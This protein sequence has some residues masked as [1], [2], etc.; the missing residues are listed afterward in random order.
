MFF[1][2]YTT[3]QTF[4]WAKQRSMKLTFSIQYGDYLPPSL[5][6]SRTCYFTHSLGTWWQQQYTCTLVCLTR[7]RASSTWNLLRIHSIMGVCALSNTAHIK[8]CNAEHNWKHQTFFLKT[9]AIWF[10][11]YTMQ[12]TSHFKFRIPHS[13]EA[14]TVYDKDDNRIGTIYCFLFLLPQQH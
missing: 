5:N 2:C 13:F 1:S 9:D 10:A 6:E 4:L 7:Q 11:H 14:N 12:G 8:K 3:K